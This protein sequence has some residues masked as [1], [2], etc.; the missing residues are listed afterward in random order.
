MNRKIKIIFTLSLLLNIIFIGMA[1]GASWRMQN[2]FAERELRFSKDL[3]PETRHKVAR[4]FREAR[5]GMH[6]HYKKARALQM[7]MEKVLRA[8]DFDE[9]AFDEISEKMLEMQQDLHVSKIKTTKKLAQE[10]SPEERK[11]F[12]RDLI[13][14]AGGPPRRHFRK[15]GKNRHGEKRVDTKVETR[16]DVPS[17]LKTG[18]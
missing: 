9:K 13:D 16:E 15:A 17:V 8:D 7:E 14:R 2:Y 4:T 11:I 3:P 12:A 1:V 10:L 6:D 5:I 18:Q